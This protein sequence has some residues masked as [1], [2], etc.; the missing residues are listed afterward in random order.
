MLRSLS[1][2]RDTR[3]VAV[4]SYPS[5]RSLRVGIPAPRALGSMASSLRFVAGTASW[6]APRVARCGRPTASWI[7]PC[8]SLHVRVR[9]EL[10]AEAGGGVPHVG[11]D[12]C[13][14]N[15]TQDAGDHRR[16]L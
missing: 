2:A 11:G 15:R 5:G 6:S 16:D 10:G 9:R 1:T 13:V 12:L 8:R 7:V 3:A 4:R 14:A